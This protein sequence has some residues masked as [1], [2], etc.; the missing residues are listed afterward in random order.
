MALNGYAPSMAHVRERAWVRPLATVLAFPVVVAS[1]TAILELAGSDE[2]DG[3]AVA[4]YLV[5]VIAFGAGVARAW[6]L[7]LPLVWGAAFVGAL[8]V[9]DLITG[10]C[11]VCTSDENWSN[12]PMFFFVIAVV[13]L[14]LA[15]GVGIL[16]ASPAGHG[17]S[18]ILTV[19]QGDSYAGRRW[20]PA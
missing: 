14:M 3:V 20:F 1:S 7:V 11:S 16:L 10:D 19:R 6:A 8:R 13:P 15:L 12:F 17:S 18:S 2:L 5:P 4:A 9:A